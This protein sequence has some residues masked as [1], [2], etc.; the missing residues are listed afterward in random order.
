VGH[1]LGRVQ[2]EKLHGE[3]VVHIQQVVNY[4]SGNAR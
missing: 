2:V 3:E 4:W 1:H